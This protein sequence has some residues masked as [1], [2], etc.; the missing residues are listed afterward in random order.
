[1]KARDGNE[2]GEEYVR[3]INGATVN[4]NVHH[5]SDVEADAPNTRVFEV[6]GSGGLLLSD[7]V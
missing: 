5:P 2:R 3:L 7:R 4:L 6:A 1:M